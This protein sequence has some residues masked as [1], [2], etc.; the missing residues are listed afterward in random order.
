MS[1]SHKDLEQLE[2]KIL[3]EEKAIE[4]LEETINTKEEKI[5][6]IQDKMLTTTGNLKILGTDFS[7]YKAKLLHS[8]FLK[9][10]N[11]HKILYSFITLL[12]VILIWYGIQNLLSSVPIINNPIV[13][14]VLGVLVVWVIDKELT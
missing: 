9:R 7:K 5:L 1:S 8:Q 4:N 12:S 13:A 2:E 6:A 10:L 11:D 3:S 14:I